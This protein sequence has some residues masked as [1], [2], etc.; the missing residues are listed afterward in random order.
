[1]IEPK[2]KQG[3]TLISKIAKT[4]LLKIAENKNHDLFTS[5]QVMR[6]SLVGVLDV[7]KFNHCRLK[8]FLFYFWGTIYNF[9]KIK[10]NF[11][12]GIHLLVPEV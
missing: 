5:F 11:F 8:Y 6:R 7:C 1:V 4:I 3:D 2:E 9:L 12:F 10:D